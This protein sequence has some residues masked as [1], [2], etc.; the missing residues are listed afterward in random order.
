MLDFYEKSRK[1][2]FLLSFQ[3]QALTALRQS[4]A[5]ID[6]DDGA[7]GMGGTASHPDKGLRDFY[8]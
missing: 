4:D 7:P 8:L 6:M 2:W 3:R 1:M 5:Q